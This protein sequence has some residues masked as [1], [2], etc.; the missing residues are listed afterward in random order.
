MLINRLCQVQT[1]PTQ[2]AKCQKDTQWSIDEI[3]LH[4]YTNNPTRA[5]LLLSWLRNVAQV[6]LHKFAVEWRYLSLTHFYSVI[7]E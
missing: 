4:I 7:L 6:E 2:P 1:D 5:Q 3:C